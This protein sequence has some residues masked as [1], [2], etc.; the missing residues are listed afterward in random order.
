MKS[1]ELAITESISKQALQY[2]KSL[3]LI[4]E[5]P[6]TIPNPQFRYASSIYYL[7][8]YHHTRASVAILAHTIHRQLSFPIRHIACPLAHRATR[9][10]RTAPR[11]TLRTQS[12]HVPCRFLCRHRCMLAS[13]AQSA[14]QPCWWN[15][16]CIRAM[17]GSS[18]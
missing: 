6:T 9:V 7:V 2:D 1:L 16:A 5:I 18:T 15:G 8:K 3:I 11:N 14:V 12:R 4:S 10:R 13:K 17:G